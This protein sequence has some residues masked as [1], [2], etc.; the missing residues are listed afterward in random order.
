MIRRPPRSTLFP[1]TTLFRS[2]LAVLRYFQHQNA[3]AEALYKRSLAI[4]N[5][6]GETRSTNFG[7]SLQ[8]L[9][10]LYLK[11]HRY[12]EAG[13]LFA[14][15]L[16]VKES[17]L[18]LEHPDVAH[19]LNEL[20]LSD[21]LQGNYADAEPSCQRALAILEKSSPP[22]YPAFIQTLRIYAQVLQ[23]TNRQAQGELLED[24][25]SVV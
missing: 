10:E 2:D 16:A 6:S 18:G 1:Y 14:Q 22:D 24:R 12:D 4:W 25:K 9:G 7:L 20:A 3:E 8:N 23:K 21:L 13:P 11:E 17:L 5:R 15:A 19:V